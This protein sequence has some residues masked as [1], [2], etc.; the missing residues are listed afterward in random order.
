MKRFCAIAIALAAAGCSRGPAF[1]NC[2]PPA[3]GL[4]LTDALARYTGVRDLCLVDSEK[5][6]PIYSPETLPY[7]LTTPLFSDYALKSRYVWLPPGAQATY[8]PDKVFDFP[9]GAILIKSFAF[10]PDLR[11]PDIGVKTVETRFLVHNPDAWVALQYI[12]NSDGSDATLQV[13]GEVTDISFIDPSGD[14]LTAHYLVPQTN[15]C[16]QCHDVITD[17]F[18]IGPKARTLNKDFQ[19]ADGTDNQ[20]ARWTSRGILAGAPAPDAAPKLPVWDDESTG[21]LDA[22]ARA[23]LE[24]NCAHCHND[25]GLARTTGLSLLS[26]ETTPMR[27]GVC[28]PPVAAGPATGGFSYDIVPGNPDQSILVYRIQSTTPAIMMPEIGR[29]VVHKEGVALIR[30]WITAMPGSCP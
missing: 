10:A 17:Q 12:W 14:S 2:M 22:R 16:G 29:S 13:G 28:K 6:Q 25:Q 1:S 26:S 15:Q 8:S 3:T 19:Y 4:T 23:W 20:L 5:G 7:D 24:S 21:S 27:Y 18:P 30:D 11:T 9:T